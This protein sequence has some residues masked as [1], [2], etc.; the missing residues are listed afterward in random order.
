MLRLK[1]PSPLKNQKGLATIESIFMALI[2][3]VLTSFG[4]GFFGIIHTGIVNSISARQYAFDTFQ[5]RT[6]LIY[7][8]DRPG[9]PVSANPSYRRF[10]FRLHTITVEEN[11]SDEF[12]A[13]ARNIAV[14]PAFNRIEG[15]STR[16]HQGL[17]GNT[18][19]PG[20]REERKINPVWVKAGYG[21]CLNAGCG[22]Q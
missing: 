6:H 14:T 11:D 9:T 8:R 12:V 13:P 22:G 15:D 5:N 18:G 20:Q 19:R 4:L 2:F 7:H 16:A 1:N 17:F 3:V 21:I 10:G